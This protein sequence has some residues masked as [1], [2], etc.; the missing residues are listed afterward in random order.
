MAK[1][2][3][4]TAKIGDSTF[5]KGEDGVW[6]DKSSKQKAPD[7]LASAL[8]KAHYTPS[9]GDEVVNKL[10]ELTAHVD[11]V[12]KAVLT[13]DKHDQKAFKELIDRVNQLN[14]TF[15]TVANKIGDG[16]GSGSNNTPVTED[17][18]QP[19]VTKLKVGGLLKNA[20]KQSIGDSGTFGSSFMEKYNKIRPGS[21][22]HQNEAGEYINS[23][24]GK[25][26]SKRDYDEEQLAQKNKPG[27]LG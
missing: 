21:F 27:R 19:P 24:T 22:I 10:D 3:K 25:Q 13:A 26:H 12:E 16:S 1:E 23:Q 18:E 11:D 5:I 20:V 7:S 14:K 4:T 8:N 6:V 9:S 2:P 15:N 17:K